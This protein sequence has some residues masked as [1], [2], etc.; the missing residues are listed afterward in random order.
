M[1]SSVP[2]ATPVAR[3]KATVARWVRIALPLALVFA[4]ATAHAR[5]GE[6]WFS[7]WTV[8]QNTTTATPAALASGGTVRMIV[9]P[10]VSGSAIRIKVENTLGTA[11][12][13]FSSAY[14][15]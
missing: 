6:K 1:I 4:A 10:T 7:A 3:R 12:V 9:R 8:S 15:G 13:A 5:G 2:A 11:A 14:V